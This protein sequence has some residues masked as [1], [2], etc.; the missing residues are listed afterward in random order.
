MKM[1]SL[2][3]SRCPINISYDHRCFVLLQKDMDKDSPFVLLSDKVCHSAGKGALVRLNNNAG[4]SVYIRV[5]Q[6]Q[7]SCSIYI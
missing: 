2:V 3:H 4:L 5:S 6:S 7:G 1:L